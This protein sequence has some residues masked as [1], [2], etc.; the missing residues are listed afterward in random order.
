[1]NTRDLKTQ[2]EDLEEEKTEWINSLTPE[3]RKSISENLR[4]SYWQLDGSETDIE[5]W[6]LDNGSEADELEELINLR[7]DIGEYY[8]NRG[9]EL[10]KE[11]DMEEYAKD[12]AE[13]TGAILRETEWPANF[14]DWEKA[15]DDLKDYMRKIDYQGTTYWIDR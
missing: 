12:Y 15:T 6:E 3:K 1:M 11:S 4:N 13:S 7:E 9:V 8:F 10:I 2:I 5:L 14:I